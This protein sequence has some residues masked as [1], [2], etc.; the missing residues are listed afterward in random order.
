[1]K[2]TLLTFFLLLGLN[3]FSQV[4][5]S[6]DTML[7]PNTNGT[8]TINGGQLYD[9]YTWYWK[10]WFTSDE[11]QVISNANGPSFTYDWFT[12]DQALF[13]VVVTLGDIVIESNTIQIDSYN[14]LPISTVFE[15]TDN[16]S[17]DGENGNVLLCAGT[18]FTAEVF[19]PFSTHIQWYRDGLAISDANAMTL[20]ISEPGVY[21]VEASPN[22]CPD[23]LSSTAGTPIVVV[24]DENCGLG[25]QEHAFALLRAYPNPVQDQLVVNGSSVINEINVI[26]LQGQT[27]LATK[28]RNKQAIINILSLASGVYVVEAVGE[29]VTQKIKIV[30]Q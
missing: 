26:N 19:N 10:Y 13:K 22:V 17:I 7:C 4:E 15:D 1:M 28:P 25:T 18:S 5:I 12:Y 24:I 16:I 3:T 23:N 21:H 14:W 20:V 6:G 27:V 8:A 9:T 2:K 29:R 30:K 11:F